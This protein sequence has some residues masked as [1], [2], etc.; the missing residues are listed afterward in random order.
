MAGT[1]FADAYE[2]LK[3]H[4]IIVLI[5]VSILSGTV[6]FSLVSYFSSTSTDLK[7]ETLKLDHKR[8]TDI[9]EGQV[10]EKDGTI[11]SLQ[12]RIASIDRTLI[13]GKYIDVGRI[14]SKSQDPT[15]ARA[16]YFSDIRAFAPP[17]S[18]RL[19]ISDTNELEYMRRI[20]TD[21]AFNGLLDEA[22]SEQAVRLLRSSRIKVWEIS[23]ETMQIKGHSLFKEI[24]T[25]AVIQRL[26]LGAT[27]T[28]IRDYYSATT[29][30]QTQSDRVQAQ[31]AVDAGG[32]F[33]LGILSS[34]TRFADANTK[35]S[36]R[37]AQ[38]K[39]NVF[40]LNML[41]SLDVDSAARNNRQL[42]SKIFVFREFMMTTTHDEAIIV[43]LLSAGKSPIPDDSHQTQ[44]TEWLERI[45]ILTDQ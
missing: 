27:L 1:D 9:L 25:I 10:E 21:D 30:D 5:S 26:R 2:R 22:G 18:S 36:V 11:R 24:P 15:P 4:P 33:F 13:G 28:A 17:A 8:K 3:K 38:R 39:G 44:L 16:E 6:V 23:Q 37:D 19:L 34:A 7:I 43:M 12:T 42:G 20:L 45:K 31:M 35:V 32:Y 14:F 41:I 40:Y 29:L